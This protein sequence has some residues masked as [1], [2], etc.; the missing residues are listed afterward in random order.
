MLDYRD[1]CAYAS[2]RRK[3]LLREAELERL[4]KIHVRKNRFIIGAGDL[5]IA[6]GNRLKAMYPVDDAPNLTQIKVQD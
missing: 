3:Q 4:V 6:A 5:L 2:D 1:A